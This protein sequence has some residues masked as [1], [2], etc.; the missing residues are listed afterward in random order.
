MVS[1]ESWM[2]APRA[3]LRRSF[4]RFLKIF[5]DFFNQS[6]N[7]V[8]FIKLAYTKVVAVVAVAA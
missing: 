2:V 6:F 7:K 4:Q 5:G 1:F 8:T 3:M